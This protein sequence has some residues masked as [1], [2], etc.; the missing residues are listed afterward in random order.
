MITERSAKG[1]VSYANPLFRSH[2]R[3]SD[4]RYGRES[5][6]E[7]MDARLR[8]ALARVEALLHQND[9]LIQQQKVFGELFASQESAAHRVVN[10]TPRERQIMELVVA[11][12]PSKNIAA[13]LG[14]SQRTVENHRASIMKKTGSKCIAALARFA[15]AAVWNVTDE[16]R[17]QQS[18][19]LAAS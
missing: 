12:D 6:N 10:L 4:A 2:E 7:Y 17:A 18:R 9:K 11:G 15:L 14:I 8:E 16:P 1:A 5:A 19:L 3:R 13:D